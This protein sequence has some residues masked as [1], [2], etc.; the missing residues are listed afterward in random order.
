MIYRCHT[1]LPVAGGIASVT[2]IWK[3][4]ARPYM[5]ALQLMLSVGGIAT[6][7][8]IRPFLAHRTKV[9]HIVPTAEND[10]QTNI[11]LAAA[12]PSTVY[13][14][15]DSKQLND[16]TV[17]EVVTLCSDQLERPYLENSTFDEINCDHNVSR[18]VNISLHKDLEIIGETKIHYAFII[19]AVIGVI[20]SFTVLAF[21]I[22]DFRH[23]NKRNKQ[24]D[25]TNVKDIDHT[26]YVISAKIKCILLAIVSF[27]CYLI[28]ALSSKV[29]ALMPS[30][31][32]LQF[33]WST[34]SASLALS[35]FWIGKAFARFVGVFLSIRFKQS[36]LIPCF[37]S[38]YIISAAG[39]AVAGWFQVND[40]AWVSIVTLGIGLSI[41]FP[42]LF[43]LTE[44]NI[45]H[46][47]GRIASLY[48]VFFVVGGMVDP[49]YTGYLMDKAS[50]M[51]FTY[52]IFFQS[53]IFLSMFVLVR[54]LLCNCGQN[55]VNSIEIETEIE[56]MNDVTK[57]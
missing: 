22:A 20:A 52:L 17:A 28:A 47:S 23:R 21:I 4:E 41:L 19:L 35:V 51:W 14:L 40:L 9:K 31:F 13:H 54:L 57:V 33:S 42:T 56:P 15:N 36:V 7:V 12:T 3:S 5:F 53:V 46:V 18:G 34:S 39:L 29:Y 43:T 24:T 49:L 32:V 8:I 55:K 26:K 50:P 1:S 11:S 27:Q 44:E 25:R 2:D 38:T 10:T 16:S 48:L 37:C 6:P 30:Y 45:S